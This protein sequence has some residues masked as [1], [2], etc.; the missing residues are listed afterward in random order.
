MFSLSPRRHE[1]LLEND[2]VWLTQDQMALLFDKDR[3]TITEHIGNIY[4][5][6]ELEEISTSRKS[7]RVQ[8]KSVVMLLEIYH[9]IIWM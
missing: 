4:K 8:K 3:K 2:T 7:Q 1:V 5:E 9:T 6:N